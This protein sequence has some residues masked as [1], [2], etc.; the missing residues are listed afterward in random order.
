MTRTTH[1]G[2]PPL[3]AAATAAQLPKARV[4]DLIAAKNT[5]YLVLSYDPLAPRPYL[6]T[7]TETG[8]SCRTTLT[9]PDWEFIF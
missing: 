7:N 1:P 4:G 5:V 9:S 3:A 2:G 6:V 8:Q